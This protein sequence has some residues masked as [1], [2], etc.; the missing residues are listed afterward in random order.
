MSTQSKYDRLTLFAYL[1][2]WE[3]FFQQETFWTHL[4]SWR[5]YSIS[6]WLLSIATVLVIARPT[7][8]WL[9]I[10][11]LT[12]NL[13]ESWLNLPYDI[14]HLLFEDIINLLILS[15][16]VVVW[17]QRRSRDAGAAGLNSRRAREQLWD[18]FAPAARVSFIL[19]YVFV[20]LAKLNVDFLDPKI[21]CA[22]KL[23]NEIAP[24]MLTD[25]QVPATS[26]LAIYGTL[27]AEGGLPLMLAFAPT[28][29]LAILLGLL[30]HLLLG[31]HPHPGVYAFSSLMFALYTLFI[32]EPL[33]AVISDRVER[34]L[35]V[36]H[37]LLGPRPYVTASILLLGSLVL[38]LGLRR[39]DLLPNTRTLRVVLWFSWSLTVI[40][41]FLL[42]A[43]E[44]PL[45]HIGTRAK[46]FAT[47]PQ[48]RLPWLVPVLV[49]LNGFM[50]YLGFKTATAFAMFSN[51][52]TEGGRSN[53]LFIPVSLQLTSYQRDLVKI[54]AF[55]NS[56]FSHP[57]NESNLL[58][59]FEFERLLHDT[60]NFS[61]TCEC[62]GTTLHITKHNGVL[63][64]FDRQ[65]SY[66]PWLGKLLS[67][68]PVSAA[69]SAACMR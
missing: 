21:S 37:R 66:D 53:H 10:A 60:D 25:A 48:T 27:I 34:T 41:V 11:M 32:G 1:W 3:G 47:V 13:S 6:W 63:Q 49:L 52:R 22:A 55:D 29:G 38:C 26:A 43:A 28:R 23:W 2:A 24:P 61:V 58:T 12:L 50:P 69:A 15:A 9:L 4:P 45:I 62:Y 18:A 17:W 39:V 64:G 57:P 68:R 40:A 20:T 19:L 36:V 35:Q 65:P 54:I 67:F 8:T 31:V 51:L 46:L 7:S 14:N 59:Q 42:S 30:F 44:T 5:K 33:A 16:V 56:A